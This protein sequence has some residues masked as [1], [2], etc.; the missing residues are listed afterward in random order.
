MI[1]DYSAY[2]LVLPLT[3]CTQVYGGE[4]THTH[5]H[6]HTHIHIHR[7]TN[8]HTQ[9]E[10]ERQRQREMS[11]YAKYAYKGHILYPLTLV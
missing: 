6:T 5:T 10:T 1:E 8:T 9:K 4:Y 7:H 2:H 3:V 11:I